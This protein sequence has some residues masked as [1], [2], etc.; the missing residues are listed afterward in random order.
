MTRYAPVLI[1]TL[2]RYEHFKRCLLS[3]EKNR[4]A[5]ETIVY[6]ALDYPLKDE[7]WKGYEK[8]KDFLNGKFNFK[9]LI[10][11]KREKN[12]GAFVNAEYVLNELFK[13]YDA[14]INS[15]DD[16]EFSPNFLEYMNLCLQKY[17]SDNSVIA[18][19]GYSFPIKWKTGD[20]NIIRHSPFCTAWG[21]GIWKSRKDWLSNTDNVILWNKIKSIKRAYDKLRKCPLVF[22]FSIE[23]IWT[24]KKLYLDIGYNIYMLLF[25]KYMIYPVISK[26]RNWG[27]D[28]SGINCNIDDSVAK[29]EL[30]TEMH[31]EIKGN[32]SVFMKNNDILVNKFFRVPKIRVLKAI[33]KYF[34]I[35]F[36]FRKISEKNV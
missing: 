19:G 24:C 2:C 15:E 11:I 13:Q 32:D 26:V 36:S 6:I 30:D 12:F 3:L 31:F 29:I 33:V 35:K 17:E 5:K 10:V 1:P 16:N 7:H 18:I 28:G 9:E 8:I 34:L 22:W 14:V 23:Y 21:F 25:D 27:W 4:L 20:N